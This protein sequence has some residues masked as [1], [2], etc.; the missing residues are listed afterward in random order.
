MIHLAFIHD[1]AKFAENGQIDKRAIEAM[2]DVLVGTHKPFIV[3][4]G[5][6]LIAPGR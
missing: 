5:T 3:T 4:S 1:F 2:G 6:A